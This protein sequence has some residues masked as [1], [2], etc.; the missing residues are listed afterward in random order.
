MKT[1]YKS[2]AGPLSFVKEFNFET[3]MAT[4]H[5]DELALLPDAQA[6]RGVLSVLK[7]LMEEDPWKLSMR[8]LYHVFL[9]VKVYSFGPNIPVTVTCPHITSSPDGSTKICG[10]INEVS[11]SLADSDLVYCPESY[12]MPKLTIPFFN[13]DATEGKTIPSYYVRPPMMRDELDLITMYEEAQVPRAHLS[14]LKEHR[15]LVLEY[16]R[17]RMLLYLR[18]TETGEGFSDREKRASALEVLKSLPVTY[19][20]DL[21]KFVTEVDKFGVASSRHQ[22]SCKSCGK[23]I[24]FRTG[25]LSGISL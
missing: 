15:D 7:D 14:D 18:D 24:T 5:F 10:N 21:T 12:E 9:M 3:V 23:P 25:L 8:E 17:H 20:R 22:V 11:F 6:E 16:A 1:L 13:E 2:C 19:L 4:K